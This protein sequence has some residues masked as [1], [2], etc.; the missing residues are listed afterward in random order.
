MSWIILIIAGLLE[1]VGV[2]GVQQISQGRRVSGLI[3]MLVGFTASLLMLGVAMESIPL[4]VAYAVWTGM[5]TVGSALLGI[6]LYGDNASVKRI[7]YLSFIVI[8]VVG[9]RLV[10]S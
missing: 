2:N 5:G 4:G 3:T 10:T 6:M 9:L 8:A 7:M 1:V